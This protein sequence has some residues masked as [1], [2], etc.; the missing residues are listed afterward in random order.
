MDFMFCNTI[1]SHDAVIVGATTQNYYFI[2]TLTT[3]KIKNL[4]W[5][6]GKSI[7]IDG[8]SLIELLHSAVNRVSRS[9]TGGFCD[10]NNDRYAEQDSGV[11]KSVISSNTVFWK[12]K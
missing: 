6:L 4:L 12:S 11:F 9:S 7:S 2:V 3:R 10:A 8:C 5:T 1:G